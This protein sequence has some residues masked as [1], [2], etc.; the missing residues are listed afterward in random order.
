MRAS[1]YNQIENAKVLM[2]ARADPFL[3][4]FKVRSISNS[5]IPFHGCRVKKQ[6]IWQEKGVT[7]ILKDCWRN[8]RE[9]LKD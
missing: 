2:E 5:S 3:R 9:I 6:E 7:I 1:E 8:M 4:D